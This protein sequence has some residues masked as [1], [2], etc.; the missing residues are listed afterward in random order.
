MYDIVEWYKNPDVT[1]FLSD[2]F[3]FGNSE[4]NAEMF[5]DMK[6]TNSDPNNKGFVIA[7]IESERYIGQ[8]DFMNIDWKNRNAELGIVIGGIDDM[9]K[10]YGSEAIMLMLEFGFMRLNFNRIYLKAFD[11]NKR[12]LKCYT[13][14]GFRE[15]GRLKE[16]YYHKGKYIDVIL[17]CVLRDEWNK[18]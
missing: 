7:E 8:V 2:I 11:F 3:L 16:A 1:D 18:S 14:C 12:A 9:S 13:K 4:K 17:M 15:E 5:V 10:G 6:M